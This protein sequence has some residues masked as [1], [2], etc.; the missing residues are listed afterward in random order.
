MPVVSGDGSKIFIPDPK[1]K[2]HVTILRT[3]FIVSFHD[4]KQKPTRYFWFFQT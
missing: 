2:G 1:R 3:K 4:C